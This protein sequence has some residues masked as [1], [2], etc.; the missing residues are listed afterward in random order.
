MDLFTQ[1]EVISIS[2]QYFDECI[3]VNTQNAGKLRVIYHRKCGFMIVQGNYQT[4]RTLTDEDPCTSQMD[5]Y[6][7]LG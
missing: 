3:N 1:Y 2:L 6:R 7:N 5:V 4:M